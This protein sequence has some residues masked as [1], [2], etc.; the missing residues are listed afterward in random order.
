MSNIAYERDDDEAADVLA[1]MHALRPVPRVSIHAFC[2][3]EGVA[4][5]IERAGQDRRMARTH[6]KVNMG[7]I[8]TAID[9][10][11]RRRRPTC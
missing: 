8:A 4:A 10:T 11:S 7:G 2:E 9:F 6:L 1:A 3:T 5:P